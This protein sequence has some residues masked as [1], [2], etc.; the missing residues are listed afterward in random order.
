MDGQT[1]DKGSH[2]ILFLSSKNIGTLISSDYFL[3]LDLVFI[4]KVTFLYMSCHM[5][6]AKAQISMCIHAV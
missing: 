6:T 3:Y 5:Q 1:M 4:S 2:N